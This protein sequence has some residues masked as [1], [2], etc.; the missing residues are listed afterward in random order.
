MQSWAREIQL[1]GRIEGGINCS[2][3]ADP[4][5]LHGLGA[6]PSHFRNERQGCH[7]EQNAYPGCPSRHVHIQLSAS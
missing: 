1:N 3:L 4:A 2:I 5:V 7:D 6:V